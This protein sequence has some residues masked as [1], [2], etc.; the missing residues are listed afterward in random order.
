MKFTILLTN[1]KRF[2]IIFS[3]CFTVLFLLFSFDAIYSILKYRFLSFSEN[4]QN[5]LHRPIS[6]DP[7]INRPK[8]T[9]TKSTP[10]TTYPLIGLNLWTN[11]SSTRTKIADALPEIPSE[12]VTTNL[13]QIPKFGIKVPILEV[14]NENQK[15]IYAALRK[16]VLVYPTTES[17][18]IDSKYSIIL[19]HSS[20]YPWEPGRYKSV[21]SLLNEF[22]VG[23]RF[24]IFWNQ[25][26][27]VYEIQDKKI[28]LPYPKG[29]DS[30]ENVFPPNSNEHILI[31]QSCWPV[32]VDY[33]RIAVKATLI[34][35]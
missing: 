10:S 35:W 3:V 33:K 19:G 9:A 4:I 18:G 22:E 1:I 32:G 12:A 34:N 24:Y 2:F 20:R 29:E 28:F 23:D 8:T 6:F 31:L 17:P 16:G 13:L 26:P 15:A 30:T 14:E 27:L 5:E 25:R 11:P 21:F 7:T